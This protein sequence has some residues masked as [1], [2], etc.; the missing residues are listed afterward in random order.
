M[1]G[2]LQPFPFV[3]NLSLNLLYILIII[4]A[5]IY[6]LLIDNNYITQ[7]SAKEWGQIL[8]NIRIESLTFS[9]NKMG[10]EFTNEFWL[11]LQAHKRIKYLNLGK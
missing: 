1:I 3:I 8:R 7:K 11:D 4:L 5:I 9:N 2:R 6:L 10:D